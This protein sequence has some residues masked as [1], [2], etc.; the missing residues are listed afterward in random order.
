MLRN[1]CEIL[2]EITRQFMTT[3]NTKLI[4]PLIEINGNVYFS[5]IT[6]G[7]TSSNWKKSIHLILIYILIKS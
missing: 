1:I 3:R 4:Q 6:D 2:A 7:Q 5:H